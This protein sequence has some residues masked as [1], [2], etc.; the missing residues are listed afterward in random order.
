[1]DSHIEAIHLALQAG[2]S[3]EAKQGGIRACRAILA[4]LE[5]ATPPDAS[6]ARP[7]EPAAPPPPFMP[8][9]VPAASPPPM[10]SAAAPP[11]VP[12]VAALVGALRGMPPE[13]L[14]D[15]AIA[16][17]RTALPPGPPVSTPAPIRFHLVPLQ[18]LGRR[19]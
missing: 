4:A 7:T 6:T 16:R 12:D 15:L 1:M 11:P 2:A 19:K 8:D 3:D 17:I 10:A 14:L 18:H 9:T 5:A 13:Q